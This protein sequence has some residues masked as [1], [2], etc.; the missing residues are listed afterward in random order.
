[1]GRDFDIWDSDAFFSMRRKFWEE[2]RD[3]ALADKEC[4]EPSS[5]QYQESWEL[6]YD[7]ERKQR[8]VA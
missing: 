5:Q 8:R 4:D 3:R 7:L 1:M 6:K 2:S